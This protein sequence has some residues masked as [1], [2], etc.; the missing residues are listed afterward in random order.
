MTAVARHMQ[1]VDEGAAC[2]RHER[3]K[4]VPAHDARTDV[5]G[6]RHLHPGGKT[7]LVGLTLAHV[8]NA[9]LTKSRVEFRQSIHVAPQLQALH[10]QRHFARV[11]ARLSAPAPVAAGLFTGDI[12][13]FTEHDRNPARSQRKCGEC[14]DNAAADHDHT[15]RGR[16]HL[17]GNDRIDIRAHPIILAE[18]PSAQP[19]P[20]A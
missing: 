4:F 17:I 19:T 16:Q 7:R 12:P 2:A 14:A 18:P 3:G 6:F 1:A 15:G 9:A 10:D 5:I 20:I 8:Q 13:F 11:T